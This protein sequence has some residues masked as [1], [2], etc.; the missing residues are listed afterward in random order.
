MALTEVLEGTFQKEVLQ[1][2]GPVLVDFWATWCAPCKALGP[3]LEE[4]AQSYQGKLKIV[5][6]NVE[7]GIQ[8]SQ[9]YGITSVPRLLFFK[10]GNVVHAIAGVPSRAKL[11]EAIQ[12]VI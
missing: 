1:A 9:R 8:T 7:D 5:K 3:V 11:E 2:T 4:V 6:F 12:K 10:G